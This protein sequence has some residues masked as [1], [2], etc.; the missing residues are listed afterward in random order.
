MSSLLEKISSATKSH[1]ESQCVTSNALSNKSLLG[2]EKITT[3]N[4]S[5]MKASLEDFSAASK[6][7]FLSQDPQEFFSLATMQI[8][9]FIEKLTL[10]GNHLNDIASATQ[11]E[12]IKTAEVQLTEVST[13][14]AT[15][16]EEITKN[17][18]ANAENA[19]SILK[20]VMSNANVGV[21][22]FLKTTKQS[23]QTLENRVTTAANKLP[24]AVEKAVTNAA[25]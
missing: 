15:L 9:P 21:D 8:K 14:A 24:Q 17:A 2:L 4:F 20:S 13:R 23:V 6:Q 19:F 18:P 7:L 3:L 22:Q 12:F 10:Y 25:A 16:M 5:I 1:I 11:I